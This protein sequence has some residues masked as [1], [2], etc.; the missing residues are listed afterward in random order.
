METMRAAL[1][2]SY[3]PPE[4]LYEGTAA[5]P[6]LRPGYLQIRVHGMSVNGGE[7]WVRSGKMAKVSGPKFPKPTGVD[8]AGEVVA[9]DPAVTEYAVGDRVWGG[10]PRDQYARGKFGTACEFVSVHPRQVAKAPVGLDLVSAAAL[11]A[12]TNAIIALRDKAGL[13][14]GETL[15]VR[16]ASGGIGSVAVQLGRAYGAR[17]TGLA[18]GANLERV[19]ALGA[20]DAFDYK[21]TPLAELGPFDVVLDTVGTDLPAL[22][23]LLSPGGRMVAITVDPARMV[24]SGLFIPASAVYGGKRVRFFSGAPKHDLFAEMT[25]LVER[26]EVAPVVDTIHPL[27]EIAKAHRLLEQGGT[28]GKHVIAIG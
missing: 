21:S 6:P 7:L 5:V 27:A 18:N 28:C 26:G 16:G 22:R 23:K 3:G 19:K 25:A 2:D 13:K 9:V 10:L 15:L 24:R 8:F 4:V 17:V 20:T 11:P 12:G 1:F 14:A